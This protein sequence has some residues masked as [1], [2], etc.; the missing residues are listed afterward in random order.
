MEPEVRA[1]AG[2]A[3]PEEPHVQR[4]TALALPQEPAPKPNHPPSNGPPPAPGSS[5]PSSRAPSPEFDRDGKPLSPLPF[6]PTPPEAVPE[7]FYHGGT[8]NI[9]PYESETDDDDYVDDKGE[10][11]YSKGKG[12]PVDLDDDDLYEDDIKPKG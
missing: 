1:E 10:G 8:S 7:S 2:P 11:K 6:V 5:N 12:K 4:E 9:S 3:P